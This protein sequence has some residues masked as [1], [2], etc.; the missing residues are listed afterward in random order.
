MQ[1]FMMRFCFA[2]KRLFVTL[3]T[4][5]LVL[6]VPGCGGKKLP[7]GMPDLYPATITI[8]QENQPLGD[9]IVML[10]SA[11]K[12]V[13]WSAVARTNAQGVAILET[14][15]QYKGVPAGT[16]KV[17][18]TKQ[19]IERPP[20]PYADA[21]DPKVDQDK[22]Q[23]WYMKNEAKIAAA[24][25]VQPK[26]TSVVDLVYDSVEKTPLTVTV[27][28]KKKNDF[29]LDVGKAVSVIVKVP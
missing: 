14:G 22:Y 2:K 3:L 17:T 4:V 25:R 13:Q 6:S 20:D 7:P 21:P 27:E 1:E 12:S 18:V 10:A 8:T 24:S 16:Y 19:E 23:E 5:A 9:A 11:D 15:G 26:V 28:A 29:T